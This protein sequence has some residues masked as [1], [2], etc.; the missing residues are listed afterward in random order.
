MESEFS[1][2]LDLDKNS[3]LTQMEGEFRSEIGFCH[4]F[5]QKVGQ[6]SREPICKGKS[7]SLSRSY[8][9][10]QTLMSHRPVGRGS[11][12]C[13]LSRSLSLLTF[14]E[15]HWVVNRPLHHTSRLFT[16]CLL[17]YWSSHLNSHILA[18]SKWSLPEHVYVCAGKECDVRSTAQVKS[19]SHYK[20]LLFIERK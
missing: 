20:T 17:S 10:E 14:A 19:S 16:L 6:S 9:C 3:K 8:A 1:P 2:S 5:I 4:H 12:H 18:E 7:L 11:T 13:L 15:S